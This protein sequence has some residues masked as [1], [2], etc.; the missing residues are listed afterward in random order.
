MIPSLARL[1]ELRDA[2]AVVVAAR[3]VIFMPI[4]DRFEAEI[5]KAEAAQGA[6][7]RARAIAERGRFKAA[8][9]PGRKVA[10]QARPRKEGNQH[11]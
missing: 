7:E 11:A 6:V 10:E 2:V 8:P 1:R 9:R 4:L 5:A 3:G